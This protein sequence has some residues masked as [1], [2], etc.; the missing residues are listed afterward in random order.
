MRSSSF[1]FANQEFGFAGVVES[2]VAEALLGILFRA[3]DPGANNPGDP[4]YPLRLAWARLWD[5]YW[6]HV[7]HR[8]VSFRSAKRQVLQEELRRQRNLVALNQQARFADLVCRNLATNVG[9]VGHPSPTWAPL[10]SRLQLHYG[11]S[12]T[13]GFLVNCSSNPLSW[14]PFFLFPAVRLKLWRAHQTS[15]VL[16]PA[17][18]AQ[19]WPGPGESDRSHP[20]VG[21][22]L[23]VWGTPLRLQSVESI[24]RSRLD[25][26]HRRLVDLRSFDHPFSGAGRHRSLAGSSP[27]RPEG[28]WRLRL[29]AAR[30]AVNRLAVRLEARPGLLTDVRPNPATRQ[31][32]GGVPNA[33]E[34][35][36]ARHPH[37]PWPLDS[38]LLGETRLGEKEPWEIIEAAYLILL[39]WRL[40]QFRA[41]LRLTAIARDRPKLSVALDALPLDQLRRHVARDPSFS[42]PVVQRL[43]RCWV[44][45][46]AVHR[47][48]LLHL[49]WL[50][51]EIG[52]LWRWH[53]WALSSAWA[54]RI[55]RAL[56]KHSTLREVHSW[57]LLRT[58]PE[59]RER[60]HAEWRTGI[61]FRDLWGKLRRAAVAL[62]TFSLSRSSSKTAASGTATSAT[63]P[64]A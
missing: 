22:I 51:L 46:V 26:D 25:G 17:V 48:G 40:F 6:L 38:S 42:G 11:G 8:K 52:K 61:Y 24:P 3:D 15:A 28:H 56:F 20:S 19:P 29:S 43:A 47:A 12:I 13:P 35:E 14:P 62:A 18:F 49:R 53:G 58:D 31:G 33:R 4:H 37:H 7:Q 21:Q 45:T 36:A 23:N 27:N 9:S 44:E 16:R 50:S 32:A 63:A 60:L 10:W 57:R 59:L 55:N 5:G 30:C 39:H 1:S 54:E 2:L 64:A 41:W 34:W